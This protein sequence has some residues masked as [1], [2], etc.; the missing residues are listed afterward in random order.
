MSLNNNHMLS[1]R[2][3][4]MRQMN[5]VLNAEDIILAE[6]ER[7]LDEMSQRASLLHEELVNESWLEE[8]LG[9]ITEGIVD[10]S[11]RKDELL[12]DISVNRGEL[13]AINER[14]TIAFIEKWLPAHLAYNLAY[15]KILG[16]KTYV[17]ALWQDDEIMTIREVKL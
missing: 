4:N 2:V 7:I 11:K 14:E 9:V 13:A 5:E 1:E 17:G 3:R 12:I 15:E 6:I 10:V 16:A 8:K